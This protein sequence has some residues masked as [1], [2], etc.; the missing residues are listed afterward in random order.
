MDAEQSAAFYLEPENMPEGDML[1]QFDEETVASEAE[2][3]AGVAGYGEEIGQGNKQAADAAADYETAGPVAMDA[4]QETDMAMTALAMDS[5]VTTNVSRELR[6]VL[7]DS[8]NVQNSTQVVNH[9]QPNITIEMGSPVKGSTA[10]EV[11]E[12]IRRTL[13]EEMLCCAEGVY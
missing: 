9:I 13:R 5:A 1:T 4:G 3:L 12:E 11:A 8:H 2:E 10:Q 6:S 7:L